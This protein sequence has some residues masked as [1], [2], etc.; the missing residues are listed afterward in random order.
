LG[1]H[2]YFISV[3]RLAAIVAGFI[4]HLLIPNNFSYILI[5]ILVKCQNLSMPPPPKKKDRK[6]TR[7]RL[8]ER[9]VT[10][11]GG[12]RRQPPQSRQVRNRYTGAEMYLRYTMLEVGTLGY[13][14]QS[15][16]NIK[17][18]LVPKVEKKI[19]SKFEKPPVIYVH[20]MH[21]GQSITF[22]IAGTTVTIDPKKQYII[23]ALVIGSLY[24]SFKIYNEF[25]VA[26]AQTEQINLLNE[27]KKIDVESKNIDLEKKKSTWEKEK[28]SA[29]GKLTIFLVEN[30]K[31]TAVKLNKQF[32]K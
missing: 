14:L 2:N 27:E 19:G 11:S 23:A 29:A 22:N 31:I 3:Y 13:I 12:G 25:R 1:F 30:K 20:N 7:E 4:V 32:V 26:S 28:D 9:G 16:E 21:T 18:E 17:N 10:K 6:T 15:L 24:T 5:C 8:Q